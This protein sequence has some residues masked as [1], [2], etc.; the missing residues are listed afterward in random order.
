MYTDIFIP[1][2]K[3]G[4]AEQG[5][6]VLVHIE[7]WPARADSPFGSVIKVL[8]KPGEHDTEIHAILAEY[9]LPSIS[10]E[11]ETFAQK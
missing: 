7:D 5:D 1:K 4:E 10:Y 11:V 8:G 6:V 3:I 2:D 9:G